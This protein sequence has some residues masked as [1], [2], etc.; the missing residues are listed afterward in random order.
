MARTYFDPDVSRRDDPAYW[1]AA[2]VVADRAGNT[3]R[4]EAARAE[5]RRLGYQLG[6]NVIAMSRAREGGNDGR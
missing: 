3:E 6:S 1:A 2:A 5:L 4:A